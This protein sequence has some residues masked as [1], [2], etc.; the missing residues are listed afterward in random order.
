MNKTAYSSITKRFHMIEAADKGNSGGLNPYNVLDKSILTAVYIRVSTER[1]AEEGFSLEAQQEALFKII[2][3]KGLRLYRVYTDPG[4]SGKNLKRPGVQAMI[5]DMKAGRVGT[6]LV[7]KLDRLSRNMGDII[8]FIEMVNKLDIRFIIAAQGED[9]IDTR[10]PMGKAFLQLNGIWAELYVNNLR[11]ETLKG[12]NKKMSAGGRHISSPP[13][14]YDFDRTVPI[15]EGEY[16]PLII[17]EEEAALV[18]EAYDLFVNRGWGVTKIAKHMNSHSTTKKG[19][20]WDNKTVRNIITNPTYAGFHHFKQEEWEEKDRIMNPG[21]HR[22]IIPME[23]FEKAKMMRA[24]RAEGHMSRRS[25]EYPFGGIVKCGCC[26]A[27]YTG[28]SSVKGNYIYRSY[29]C[30]NNYSK[31]TC[32][33][34]SVSE[35]ELSRLV[36]ESVE[37]MDDS[38]Q[39]AKETKQAK[40]AR[41]VL[42]KE[43]EVS[44]RR[45]KNWMIA[46]GD[47]NLSSE[48]YGMLV[49]EEEKRMKKIYN[50]MRE[51]E[52]I[53]GE[54]STED[55]KMMVTTLNE[56]WHLLETLTQ[57][58]LI[59][60]M[61]RKIVIKKESD[62]WKLTQ[63]LTV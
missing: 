18:R 54:I 53:L 59:Q 13:L 38:I 15:A 40:K 62:K 27:T 46:L 12:L 8:E 14:G 30:L 19:G 16:I 25:F 45:R 61:F 11:E 24:R 39:A 44:N 3:R 55:L 28:N 4:I 5:A 33:S 57:K 9:E 31:G 50:E 49:E 56:N 29:R 48:D 10:S 1:Q 51:E 41:T 7:H 35:K 32:D 22:P 34:P 63:L 21:Q 43:I 47:G 20:K 2:E 37:L 26:G 42:Q 17:V 23:W 60:S 36:F 58:E 52:Q 6:V